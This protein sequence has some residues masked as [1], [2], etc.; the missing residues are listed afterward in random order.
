MA[1][2]HSVYDTDKHFK[3]DPLTRKIE[4]QSTSK[5]ILIQRD[6]DSERFTFEIPRYI[7]EHD[8]SVCNKVE[9][10]YL[11]IDE[12]TKE[13]SP[14]VY[15]VE[16]LQV[17]PDSEDVVICSWLISNKATKYLGPLSFAVRFACVTGDVIDYDWRT[18]INSTFSVS[19]TIF[20]SDVIV[21]EYF[22]ILE[23]WKQEVLDEAGNAGSSL[24]EGG[25]E[26]QVLTKT[27][28]GAEWQDAPSGLPT[29]DEMLE[30]VTEAGLINPVTSSTGEIYTTA[31]GSIISL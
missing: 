25:T 16:D 19:E 11:N 5:V 18:G 10:H 1:H 14:G 12:T 27:V 29:D 9:V 17:S 2:Q 20:N 24:P 26:G 28:D 4:N 15:E 6:H 7:E 30:L 8:M 21:E 22:D 13:T 31:D 3:I 23:Q